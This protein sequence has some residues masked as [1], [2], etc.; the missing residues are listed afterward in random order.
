MDTT[1]DNIT[2]Q[3]INE[4]AEAAKPNPLERRIDM[5][6]AMAEIEQ[7]VEQQL[8]KIARTTKMAGFRPGKVPMKMVAQMYGGQARSEALGAAIEKAFGAAV[9]E[10]NLRVA[11]QP[12]IEPKKADAETQLAFT[13]IFE[14]FPEFAIADISGRTIEKPALSVGD[15]EVDKT[16]EVLQK[17]R[18]TYAAAGRA[19]Q[20]GDRLVIDFTGRRNGEIFEGGAATDYGVLVGDGR[21]IP[22]F[23]AALE[24][25]V[26]G[27]EK[28]FD[29]TFPKDYHALDLAGNTVQFTILVKAVEAPQLPTIDAEFA[30]S[31]GIADGD[32][33]KMR[34]EVRTNLEREVAKRL[35]ARIKEQAMN[36]LLET[37]PIDVPT[38][39]VDAESQQ[40]AD[41]ARQDLESRGAQMKNIPVNASWFTE[42]AARRVRL[43]LIVAALV[44]EKDLHVQPA[45]VR[46]VV[47]DFA[48]TFE[49]P[50]EVVRW[51][52][53]QP[54]RLAE[55]EALA[56]ENNV[57]DWVLAHAQVADKDVA[58]D[59]LMGNGA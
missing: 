54:Q 37:H 34:A 38:A 13:A 17:Q 51:Y 56:M 16:I 26:A 31:L 15:A 39:M 41:K 6:V 44:Q 7:E 47:D 43:G 57:V 59:E 49:D 50:Q 28:V 20:K 29:A 19:A 3:A 30:R 8:K 52:Y 23:E 40:M 9:R 53:S 58:F 35:R 11:G 1:Q 48:A 33:V 55:A 12:R 46:A 18:T 2:T 10:Q 42:Q 4:A 21:M 32:T 25:V 24:G 45:S 5:T 22:D 14:V 36:A 27:Q